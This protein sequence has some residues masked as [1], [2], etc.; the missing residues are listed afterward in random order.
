VILG[1]QILVFSDFILHKIVVHQVHYPMNVVLHLCYIIISLKGSPTSAISD[2]S[3]LFA[4][5]TRPLS[6]STF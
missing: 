5:V 2:L 4:M 3:R 6:F 1:V